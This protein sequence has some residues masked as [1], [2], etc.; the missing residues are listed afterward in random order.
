MTKKRITIPVFIPHSG[1]PHRCV[2]CNQR[3]ATGHATPSSPALV[4]ELVSEYLPHIGSSVNRVEL[5]FFGGSFTGMDHRIQ[6]AYLARARHHLDRNAIHGIRLSTRPDYITDEIVSFLA[7]SGVSTIEL[8]VQS[9]DDTVLMASGRGHDSTATFRAVE[10]IHR[11]GID[12]VI[13]L[14]PGLPGET[15]PSALRSAH[16][17]AGLSPAGVRIYPTVVLRG[18]AL[19]E[20]YRS[21]AYVPLA[22]DEAIELCRDIYGV[23]VSRGIPV[24]R[25]GIHPLAPERISA[26][27]AGPYHP[28]FGHLVKARFRRDEMMAIV[29]EYLSRNEH[30]HTIR[31][32]IPSRNT[33]EYI[34]YRRENIRHIQHYFGLTRID[35]TVVTASRVLIDCG[36]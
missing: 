36:T 14:M 27:V 31:F 10:S 23:F 29:R 4:D 3:D 25:M 13:Q 24:I 2:F 32:L 21:G 33:E 16:I 17:A 22:M 30:V 8:G 7:A 11:Q 15:R 28:S 19:E 35:F 5:A 9:F 26:V 12:L 20:R 18:T 1:C 6:E 34:G